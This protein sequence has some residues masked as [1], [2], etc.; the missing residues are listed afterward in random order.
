MATPEERIADAFNGYFA[1]FDI[2]LGPEDVA[3]GTHRSIVERGWLIIYRVDPDDGG[4]PVL[5][6]YATHRM[7]NDS[8][9][10]IWA[11]GHSED[12]D[13][14]DELYAYDAKVPGSKE[15]A[16]EQYLRHNRAVADELRVR[17]LYPHGDINAFLR[18]GG[19]RDSGAPGPPESP[20][21]GELPQ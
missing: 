21:G 2:H 20:D 7:T 11:D 19:D 1:N 16:Q 3:V 18:T 14:I 12:L 15:A 4:F 8:H 17:G 5:E 10:R 6:F 9:V 13:A